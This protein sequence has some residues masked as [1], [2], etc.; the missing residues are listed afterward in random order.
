MVGSVR[1]LSNLP[2]SLIAKTKAAFV[3]IGLLSF[4]F[5]LYIN[6]SQGLLIGN[7]GYYPLQVRTVLERN[8]LAF[9]DMPLLFYLDAGIVKLLSFFG[10]DASNE[11]ILNVVKVVDSISIPLLLIPLYHILKH[12]KQPK[13]NNLTILTIAFSVLSFHTINLVST[14]QK[15]SLAITF[16]FC[17]IAFWM[18]YLDAKKIKYAMFSLSF[19]GLI[20]LTHFGTFSFALLLASL[21]LIFAYRRKA[22]F[23]LIAV[24]LT[25]VALIY[26]FDPT[27]SLRL[28]SV[29]KDVFMVLPNAGQF[30]VMLVYTGLGVLAF[31]MFRKLKDSFNS[32]DQVVISTLIA[33]LILVPIPVVN[34]QYTS[35]LIGFLFIPIVLLLF[36]F[37]AYLSRKTT[38]ILSVIIGLIVIGSVAMTLGRGAP[39]ELSK[40]ALIDLR[41][42]KAL[43]SNPKETVIVSKHNL[44]FWVAWELE[45]S[46]SQEAKFDDALIRDYDEV[47]IINHLET[48]KMDPRENGRGPSHFDE[49]NIPKN[50]ELIY[51]SDYFKLYRFVK[52]STN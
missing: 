29:W 38:N 31:L 37:N 14:S 27:R 36:Y 34:P 20:G 17:A 12:I 41:N 45:V 23:P 40:E 35:R 18:L 28:L 13:F 1:T 2:I 42:M 24:L 47:L 3:F 52:E 15:N 5:R 21:M 22:I 4:F 16:L 8:E 9:S 7:G 50:S 11:L 49:P 25:G 48:R 32:S 10:A 6:I 44:E 26:A 19:L 30:A 51:A 33:L 39:P 46:V 43:I